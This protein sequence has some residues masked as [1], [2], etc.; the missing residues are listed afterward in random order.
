MELVDALLLL[1]LALTV[2]LALFYIVHSKKRGVKCIGCP[3]GGKCGSDGC[4]S[5][6]D[7]CALKG[8]SVPPSDNE[9][10]NC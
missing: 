2:L 4:S 1:V 7:G 8:A 6:C 10:S 9:E 3:S 5:G